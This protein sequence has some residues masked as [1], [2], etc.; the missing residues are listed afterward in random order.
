MKNFRYK[1]LSSWNQ[2]GIAFPHLFKIEFICIDLDCLA[3]HN[4]EKRLYNK[5]KNEL[6]SFLKENFGDETTDWFISKYN[7]NYNYGSA[8]VLGFRETIHAT[9][10][11]MINT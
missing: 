1:I 5:A 11:Y 4:D 8:I 7:G 2:D 3:Q 6:R 10:F 9:Y